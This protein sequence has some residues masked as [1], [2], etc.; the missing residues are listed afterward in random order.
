M[1]DPLDVVP[2]PLDV[3]GDLKQILHE[4]KRWEA[5]PLFALRALPSVRSWAP[6]PEK[7]RDFVGKP[8]LAVS[9]AAIRQRIEE[10]IT[11]IVLE[12]DWQALGSIFTFDKLTLN[13]TERRADAAVYRKETS[14]SFRKKNEEILLRVLAEEMYRWELEQALRQIQLF[15]QTGELDTTS[16][17]AGQ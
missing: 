5:L 2:T 4:L 9:N 8:T 14:E 10:A 13:L 15:A 6:P 12:E 1:V 3:E 16:P 17:A 11:R 7:C